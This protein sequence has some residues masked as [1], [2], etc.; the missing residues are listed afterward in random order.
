MGLPTAAFCYDLELERVKSA[1]IGSLREIMEPIR[2][3]YIQN[4]HNA[5]GVLT[6]TVD[7]DLPRALSDPESSLTRGIVDGPGDGVR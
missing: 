1:W 7:S 4:T 2:H 3:N 6:S 5:V